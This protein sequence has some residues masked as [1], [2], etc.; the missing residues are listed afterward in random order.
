LLHDIAGG[1]ICTMPVEA[2]YRNPVTKE[3]M[4][5][6]LFGNAKYTAEERLR[7]LYLAQEIGSSKFTGYFIGWGVNAAGSPAA[8]EIFVRNHYDLKTSVK[9]AK[10]W[11]KIG[12][13]KK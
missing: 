13:E 5:S 12:K 6:Y 8:C 3:W 2:D 11:A 9:V 7:A 1:I 4:D 10:E